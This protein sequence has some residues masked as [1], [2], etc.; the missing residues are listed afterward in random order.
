MKHNGIE[1]DI[2]SSVNNK[3]KKEVVE[4]NIYSNVTGMVEALLEQENYISYDDIENYYTYNYEGNNITLCDADE[5]ELNEAIDQIQV[6]IDALLEKD[7]DAN[8]SDLEYELYDLEHLETEPVKIYEWW[9]VS[10]SFLDFLIKHK[11]TVI[12]DENLW[13]RYTTG[14]AI[15]MDNII[16]EYCKYYNLYSEQKQFLNNNYKGDV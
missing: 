2:Y 14:Q 3:I 9:I 15:Y 4:I 1:I 13:G 11:H 5:D 6:M 10:D 16:H 8:I 7:E 12:E